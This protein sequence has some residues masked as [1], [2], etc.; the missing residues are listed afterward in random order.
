MKLS[1]FI[2]TSM[3]EIMYEWEVFARTLP[4]FKHV[5]REVLI[6]HVREILEFIE[7]DMDTPQTALAQDLKSKGKGPKEGGLSDSA[8][9]T[10]ADLRSESGFDI[11]DLASEYRALRASVI[12]LWTRERTQVEMEDFWDL[13]RFNEAIDQAL[14]ESIS[15]FKDKLGH[16]KDMLL[17]IL[18]HDLRNP[19]SA[20]EMSAG[21]LLS[22]GDMNDEQTFLVTQID[23]SAQRMNQM[24]MDLLD[25]TRINLGTGLPVTKAPMDIGSVGKQIAEEIQA[26]HPD[27]AISFEVTGNLKGEWDSVRIAQLFSNLIG[28]A[29]Q[30]GFKETPITVTVTGQPDEIIIS[31]HNEGVPIPQANMETIFDSFTHVVKKGDGQKKSTSL[32]LGLYIAKEIVDAHGGIIYATS[33]E[34]EG[35]VFTVRLPRRQK[36]SRK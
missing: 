28:N 36:L 13:I 1:D 23:I 14:M 22:E 8:A 35:T 12:K 16:S 3:E 20:I 10:H 30:H 24:I 5:N 19:L 33:F 29:V 4:V 25:V 32:G 9:Q 6:D 31:V 34:K 21:L 15:R 2:R 26:A 17:G 27:R 18:G 11:A 7:R